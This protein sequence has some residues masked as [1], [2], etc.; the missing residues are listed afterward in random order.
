MRICQKCPVEKYY[1]VTCRCGG[2]DDHCTC[3]KRKK[4]AKAFEKR[5]RAL[6]TKSRIRRK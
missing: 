5:W 2:C 4:I 1:Y 6:A 3:G